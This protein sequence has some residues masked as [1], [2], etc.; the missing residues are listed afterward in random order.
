MIANTCIGSVYS[1]QVNGAV[2]ITAVDVEIAI[3][4]CPK[5]SGQSGGSGEQ[6]IGWAAAATG[7]GQRLTPG[8]VQL[9]RHNQIHA[10]FFQSAGGGADYRAGL[11]GRSQRIYYGADTNAA[12]LFMA[13]HGGVQQHGPARAGAHT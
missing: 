5:A 4:R 12:E 8:A 2:A 1:L 9:I 11:F 3:L 6:E 13:L 10:A 7:S